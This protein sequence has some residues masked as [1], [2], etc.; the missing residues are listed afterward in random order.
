M[1]NSC[2]TNGSTLPH[3]IGH[4]FFL[5]HTHGTTN[6]GTTDEVVIRPGEE[7]V[8][9][10]EPDCTPTAANCDTNGD[11]LCDT[12]ADP[13]VSGK[14]DGSDCSYTENET[15]VNGDAFRP[16]PTNIMSYSTKACRTL[17]SDGQYSRMNNAYLN[18]RNYLHTKKLLA[19][20]EILDDEV[21]KGESVSFGDKSINASSYSWTFDGGSPSSSTEANPQVVYANSGLYDVTLTITDV[22]GDTHTKSFSEAI[23]VRE[24]ITSD[25]TAVSGSFESDGLAETIIS[26][27]SYTWT[28]TTDAAT[29]GTKSAYI[30]HYTGNTG[31]GNYLVLDP[32]KTDVEKYF[33]LTFDYAFAAVSDDNEDKLEVIYR[34]PCGDWTTAWEKSGQDLATAPNEPSVVFVPTESQ[35]VSETV[36]FAVD[37]DVDVV[38]VAFRSTSDYGNSLYVDNYAAD[39][40]DANFSISEAVATNASC[41][42]ATDGSI[43]ISVSASGTYEYSIDGENFISSNVIKDLLPGT[44]D[45]LA[46]SSLGV[47]AGETVVVGFDNEYPEV[48]SITLSN[49]RLTTSIEDGQSVQWYRNEEP[50]AGETGVEL[51]LDTYGSYQVEISNGSCS[52]RSEAFIILSADVV[53]LKLDIFPN[54]ADDYLTISLPESLKKEVNQVTIS[55]LS[56]KQIKILE[57]QERLDVSTLQR[58]L[59]LIHFELDGE[60]INRRFLKQ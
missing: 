45:V 8:G 32:L 52:V 5:Y 54:P 34:S 18:D 60:N 30:F 33:S 53:D 57:F 56:G 58:G 41:P 21:C 43:S 38:E 11:R 35:W 7:S 51:D 9:C 15:D 13:N 6:T 44:Y 23:T 27:G 46:R 22:E 12:E 3:E 29:E 50:I 55:D 28:Q 16:D 14:V 49:D 36:L 25:V 48:P 10:V 59:Y 17:F 4:F 1:A 40:Y 24:D 47:E 39:V 2:T 31:D 37:N 42:D 19:A 20:F 26:N